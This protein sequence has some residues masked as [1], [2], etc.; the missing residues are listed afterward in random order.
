MHFEKDKVKMDFALMAIA[1]NLAKLARKKSGPSEKPKN[2]P[3]KQQL[4][5]RVMILILKLE[6][7]P[8]KSSCNTKLAA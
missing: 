3:V 1:L 8:T 4:L 7:Q 2:Q 5:D 6:T